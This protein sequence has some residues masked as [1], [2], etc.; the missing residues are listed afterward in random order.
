MLNEI[1]IEAMIKGLRPEPTAQYFARKHPRL[2]RSC[3]RKWMSTSGLI[4]IS[5]KEGK[6]LIGFLRW[7]GA[8][9]E[10]ST[11]GM[12]DQSTAP[13]RAMIK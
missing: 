13:V 10:E 5:A 4:M 6:K 3:F 2:W 8:S 12:S 11:L 7:L 9:E 1:V